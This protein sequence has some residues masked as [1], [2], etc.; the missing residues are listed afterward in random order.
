MAF[1]NVVFNN[2]AL[3]FIGSN[4]QVRIRIKNGRLQFRPTTR[5]SDLNLPPGERLRP[6]LRTD[7]RV[8]FSVKEDF[9]NPDTVVAVEDETY[10]WFTLVPADIDLRNAPSAKLSS[11]VANNGKRSRKTAKPLDGATEH[12]NVP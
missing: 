9:L 4:P 6:I 12:V 7:R 8:Y 10:G 11:A 1:V 3:K 2:H 5:V